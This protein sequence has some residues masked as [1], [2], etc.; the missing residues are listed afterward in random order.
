M[1]NP[2]VIRKIYAKF[3]DGRSKDVFEHRLL[4]SLTGDFNFILK[5][6][7]IYENNNDIVTSIKSHNK[8]KPTI[9]YGAGLLGKEIS[10]LFPK[11]YFM[12]ICDSAEDKWGIKLNG[13][14]II[15]PNDMYKIYDDNNILICIIDETVANVVKE[16]LI[17]HGVP[18]KRIIIYSNF[19]YK[20][21]EPLYFPRDINIPWNEKE[22]FIDA[23][24]YNFQTSFDFIRNM[25]G[26][27]KKIAAFEPNPEQY[28]ICVEKARGIKNATVYECGLW[29]KSTILN[30]S[31]SK[32]KPMSSHFTD[33]NK[34]TNI[35][36]KAVKLDDILNGEEATFIKMD[37]EGAELNALKGAVQTILRYKPKLAIC[38]YHKPE[39]IWEIPEYIINLR[40]DYKIYMRHHSV[41]NIDTVLYAV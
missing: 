27:Y 20:K 38:L 28:E 4:Y 11:V 1:I 8:E 30:F 25:K 21:S 39:D 35:K 24:C 26:K 9:L 5:M 17:K 19:Q 34:E 7:N 33:N 31:S 36:I 14:T 37:I 32:D 41:T 6:T 16:T 15:S 2:S 22:V 12:C 23:G 29:N 10:S 13:Y 3:Q 18:N 40:D